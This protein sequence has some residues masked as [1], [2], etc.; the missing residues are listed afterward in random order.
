MTAAGLQALGGGGSGGGSQP[1]PMQ[2]P[3][4]PMARASGG[5]MMIGP[6]G[7][8]TFGARAAEQNLAQQGFMM[9]PSLAAF[10]QGGVRPP[11]QSVMPGQASGMTGLPG[12]TLNSP[13]QMQMA[14]MT[15][16]ISPYD[17]YANSAAYGGG[18]G[19]S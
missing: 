19:S 4:A 15:G 1:Q 11:V 14:L 10:T 9:Q 16:S 12:T 2:L 3:Q 17:M 7:Q 13:S 8:N 18:F 5:P 6:G